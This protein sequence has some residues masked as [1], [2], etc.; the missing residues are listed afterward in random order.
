M[1]PNIPA[2]RQGPLLA[3][4]RGTQG[5][6][7]FRRSCVGRGKSEGE[8]TLSNLGVFGS[9]SQTAARRFPK[10]FHSDQVQLVERLHLNPK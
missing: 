6:T 7:I 5:F 4:T 8:V 3:G 2:A 1:G 10:C 9:L